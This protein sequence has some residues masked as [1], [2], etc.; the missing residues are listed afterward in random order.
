MKWCAA[1]SRINTFKRGKAIVYISLR[2]SV[3]SVDLRQAAI[4]KVFR[5]SKILSFLNSL[6]SQFHLQW[7]VQILQIKAI[8]NQ[9]LDKL[10]HNVSKFFLSWF[11]LS[12]R[13]IKL[14]VTSNTSNVNLI[15]IKLAGWKVTGPRIAVGKTLNSSLC[16]LKLNLSSGTKVKSM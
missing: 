15:T 14:V 5:F 7:Q 4:F 11:F 3:N 8:N 12:L 13:C 2:N 10:L 6:K 9:G 16:H 1:N